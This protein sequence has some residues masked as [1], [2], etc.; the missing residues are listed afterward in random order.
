MN[1][2]LNSFVKS[3]AKVATSNIFKLLSG[4]LVGFLLPKIISVVD[5]GYYKTFTLYATYVGLIAIG[6]TDG[7]YL[8]FGGKNYEELDKSLFR[9]YSKVFLLLEILL[10][11]LLSS[12]FLIFV[13]GE[14]RFIFVCLCFYTIANNI[15]GYYQILSQ[16]TSR[17]GELSQRNLIQAI[18]TSIAILTLWVINRFFNYPVSY[19]IYTIIFVS[20]TSFLSIWYIISYRDVT[21]GKTKNGGLK[22][23]TELIK[24]GTPL[25]IANL[26]S[27]L[28]LSIDRQFVNF[29]FDTETY[30][31]YAFAYNMLALLTTATSAISTVFYPTMKKSDES[32][33]K[34]NY[35]LFVG[36][37]LVFVFACL[38]VYYPL[39]WF[40]GWFLPKYVQSLPIFRIILPGLAIQCA[41]TIV[42][43]N[44]YKAF[45]KNTEFF[46]KSLIVLIVSTGANFVAYHF[47]RNTYSISTASVVTLLFWYFLSEEMLV[48]KYSVKWE[49]NITYILIMS[50]SFYTIT[51]FDTWW[52][53]ML[54][55]IIVFITVSYIFYSK[56]L[57]SFK[58][59]FFNGGMQ[60]KA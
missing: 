53:G 5:Y 59:D 1:S 44:Y 17:F 47:C 26:C 14:L 51:N 30:A 50:I 55:Y 41:I 10:S 38:L 21:F 46:I 35:S 49:K 52:V 42:M 31:V 9:F 18:L 45:G 60:K 13:K 58:K 54:V 24:I 48:R 57:N 20:I 7:V 39:Y 15:T 3:V 19:K 27:F 33:L 6:I 12:I 36:I 11:L 23:I 34:K 8:K 37:I 2:K 43:H 40:I 16:V 22:S 25:L 32:S 56:E 29:L 4:V 28:I